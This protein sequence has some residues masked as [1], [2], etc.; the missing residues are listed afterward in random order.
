MSLQL[1]DG[2]VIVVVVVLLY[3]ILFKMENFDPKV[4]AFPTYWPPQWTK[5]SAATKK[6]WV[7][8]W[9]DK[10]T[11]GERNAYNN[12]ARAYMIQYAKGNV[13]RKNNVGPFVPATSREFWA[14]YKSD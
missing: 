2:L 6:S 7:K 11:K 14:I 10:N 1:I 9:A 4:D 5:Y 3:Y 8:A 12:R 13:S